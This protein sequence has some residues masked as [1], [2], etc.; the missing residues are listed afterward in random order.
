MSGKS[1]SMSDRS[2]GPILQAQPAL[3]TVSVKRMG[4]FSSIFTQL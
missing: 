1:Q 3:W 4:F 2:P